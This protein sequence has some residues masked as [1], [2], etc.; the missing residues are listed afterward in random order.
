MIIRFPDI[1]VEITNSVMRALSKFEQNIGCH[2]AGGILMGKYRPE[3]EYYLI[4]EITEPTSYDQFGPL[5][6]FATVN[7]FK[8]R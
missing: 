8:I 1:T 6:L 3:E 5:Y 7:Q 4:S 2:E